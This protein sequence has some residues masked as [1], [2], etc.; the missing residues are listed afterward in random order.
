MMNASAKKLLF[1]VQSAPYDNES[2]LT[3]LR[4][5]AVLTQHEAAPQLRIFL[6]SDA[7]VTALT[8][9]S[10]AGE[11]SHGAMLQEIMEAGAEVRICRSCIAARGLLDAAWL[12]G[13]VLGT[14]SELAQWVLEAD[15][16]LTF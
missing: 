9:Q 8:E 15:Q 4:L 6:L 14:M 12:Q 2:N 1:I 13:V 5:A 3:V 11:I 7:V 16:V 10:V